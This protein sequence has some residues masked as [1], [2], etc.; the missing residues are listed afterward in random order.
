MN[1]NA[2]QTARNAFDI[3]LVMAGHEDNTP[4]H[5]IPTSRDNLVLRQ[6]TPADGQRYFEL[7]EENR[8][9]LAQYG[10][11]HRLRDATLEQVAEDIEHEIGHSYGIYYDERLIGNVTLTEI[12]PENFV[13]GHWIDSHSTGHSFVRTACQALLD[14][15]HEQLG[16]TDVH[17]G[18]TNGNEDSEHVLARLG[19]VVIKDMGGYRRFHLSLLPDHS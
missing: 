3:L 15:A 7:K 19:F 12:N 8:E 16:A 5:E 18:V 13:L 10:D 9:H 11:F 14:Y 4:A 1:T 2:R 17:A 6:L